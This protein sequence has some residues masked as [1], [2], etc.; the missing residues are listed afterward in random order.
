MIQMQPT[1]EN[2]W[3]SGLEKT[4]RQQISEETSGVKAKLTKIGKVFPWL[5][6]D[7]SRTEVMTGS[8]WGQEKKMGF[9]CQPASK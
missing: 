1:F 7:G 5:R 9:E 8:W 4:D 3:S 2:H 6:D